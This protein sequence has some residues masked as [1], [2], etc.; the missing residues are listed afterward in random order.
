MDVN[1][2]RQNTNLVDQR[3]LNI[4]E[5]LEKEEQNQRKAPLAM[6]LKWKITI[7]NTRL[8]TAQ[9][10]IV[11]LIRDLIKRPRPT[12]RRSESNLMERS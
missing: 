12:R 8:Q 7:I 10:G 5:D 4:K 2:E 11:N 1:L 3:S 6:L 9:K